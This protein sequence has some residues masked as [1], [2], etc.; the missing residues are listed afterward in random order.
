MAYDFKAIETKWQK[1]WLDSKAFEVSEDSTKPKYYVLEMFPYPSGKVHMGHLRNYTIG[2][3][4]ARFKRLQGYNVL[5][6]MGWDAF[7]LPAENAAIERSVHP[8]EWTYG[9]IES[10]RASI[11]SSGF[12]YDWSRELASCSADYYGHEQKIFI[13][14]FNK[15]IAYKKE[16][17]VNWDPIDKTVLA[18]EQVVDGKGWRSGA[19]VGRK[20]LSQWFLKITNYADELLSGLDDLPDW[21]DAVK[22]IQKKWIGKSQ[23][24]I[25]N[26]DIVG[27]DKHIKVYTTRHD[28]LYGAS[29]CALAADHEAALEAAANNP[30]LKSF[31]DECKASGASEGEIDKLEKKAFDTGLRVKSPFEDR[32]IPVLV[33]NFVLLE[34]G[35]GAVFGCPAHDNRDF[36]LAK[37]YDL[38][39]IPVI[40]SP[41][42][43]YQKGAY[44]AKAGKVTRS[45]FL[46]GMD[47]KS[48][49]SRALEELIKLGKGRAASNFRVRDWGVSRQ[50][51]WG[52]PIPI[53]YCDSCGTVP[54]PVADLPIK[55]PEDINFNG[56][57]NPLSDHPTWSKV[58]CPTCGKGAKREVDTLDTFFESSWY[59]MRFCD[60]KA[61]NPIS[62]NSCDYWLPVDQYIGGIEHAAMHLLYARFFTKAMRDCGYLSL[63]EPFQKLLTQGMV[64]HE[65]YKDKDGKW[66]YP[67][68]AA[69]RDDIIIGRSE[70]MSKS[71][72]NVVEPTGLVEKYGADT[73]R[74]FMMSDS[75]PE[76][77]LHWLDAGVEGAWKYLNRV[78]NF[79]EKV[80]GLGR[81]AD[82]S[83]FAGEA[84]EV[85]RALHKCIKVTTYN[86]EKLALNVAVANI[87]EFSNYLFSLDLERKE[88]HPAIIESTKCMILLLSPFVPHF[89]SEAWEHLAREDIGQESWPSYDEKLIVDD[90]VTIAVQV[91]G[92][93]K[94]TIEAVKDSKNELIEKQAL[95]LQNVQKHI[96]GKSVKKVIVIK[97]RIVNVVI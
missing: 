17:Y 96:N 41:S 72:K 55:L 86:V 8:A 60:P 32:E 58:D 91:N 34:Y 30:E 16:S 78:W 94:G 40:E 28:T 54:V 85:R 89:S 4:L 21:P 57:G 43:D 50:R 79:V 76:R 44:I 83:S 23:G 6:P 35:T 24:V 31:I 36:Q 2:D 42:H 63:D 25:I 39:I 56:T 48:A 84:L 97:N 51:Y 19:T 1:H 65:T 80:S 88:L 45:E 69:G 67:S 70:K 68:E 74:L 5:H 61:K 73:A 77:D 12:S 93:L 95:E 22:S 71:K 27:S 46:N 90:K 82:N 18:N 26:F 33:A 13:D 64:L 87:R 14:F 7:G 9:N 37:K 38:D 92:K 11:Q 81:D 62:K 47:I 52:A 20:K 15:G 29:F 53:I 66:L 10:M 49:K 59:F 75:P 3:V